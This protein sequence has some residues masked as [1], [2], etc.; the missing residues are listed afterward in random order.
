MICSNCGGEVTWRG[1]WSALTH[2]QCGSCGG[3]GCQVAEEL[4]DAEA[5]KETLLD[6]V[7]DTRCIKRDEAL[8]GTGTGAELA[9]RSR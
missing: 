1:P 9:K 8:A 4:G 6:D 5:G 7:Y 3:I 2:T